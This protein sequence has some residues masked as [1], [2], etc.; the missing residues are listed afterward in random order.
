[1]LL[2]SYLISVAQVAMPTAMF[3]ICLLYLIVELFYLNLI[4][5]NKGQLVVRVRDTT[6]LTLDEN[7]CTFPVLK[8]SL[9]KGQSY[10]ADNPYKK[11][12]SNINY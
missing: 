6:N 10:P 2:R 8:S 12:V 9:I 1:M 5:S 4:L 3:E 11:E 7:L